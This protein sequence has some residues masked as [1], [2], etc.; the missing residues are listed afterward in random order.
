MCRKN[1]SIFHKIEQPPFFP[2]SLF[3]EKI[4]IPLTRRKISR[5]GNLDLGIPPFLLP[6]SSLP[7]HYEIVHKWIEWNRIIFRLI[8][9][10]KIIFKKNNIPAN[11]R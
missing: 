10:S 7:F 8:L 2:P 9:I 11:V 1:R 3:A 4:N 6:L 5:P